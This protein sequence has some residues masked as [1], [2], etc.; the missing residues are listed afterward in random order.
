MRHCVLTQGATPDEWTPHSWKRTSRHIVWSLS[1]PRTRAYE[2]IIIIIIIISCVETSVRVAKFIK[3]AATKKKKH[4]HKQTNKNKTATRGE[5]VLYKIWWLN[6]IRK[7]GGVGHKGLIQA[8][9]EVN[10]GHTHTLCA[11]SLHNI[12]RTHVNSYCGSIYRHDRPHSVWMRPSWAE[13]RA[14]QPNNNM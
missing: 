4:P 8:G 12:K 3:A 11:Q 14:K 9:L 7:Q 2:R 1:Q 5:S 13:L 6:I 10:K